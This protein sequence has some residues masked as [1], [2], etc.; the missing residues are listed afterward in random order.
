MEPETDRSNKPNAAANPPGDRRAAQAT[1][2]AFLGAVGKKALY[3][4]PVVMTL[5][6]Q[7]ARATS[8][9]SCG[10][11]D[12]P[13]TTDEDCCTTNCAAGPMT[14]KCESSNSGCTADIECCSGVCMGNLMCE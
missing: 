4:T 11:V 8:A 5:T 10:S 1:R 6:A 3:V 14:C 9:V 12:T 2:R 7:Q 13:C